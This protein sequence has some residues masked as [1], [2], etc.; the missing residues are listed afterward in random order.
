MDIHLK[1]GQN[2]TQYAWVN[3]PSTTVAE[4]VVSKFRR[5]TFDG[6][7]IQAKIHGQSKLL[8]EFLNCLCLQNNINL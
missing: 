2:E 1:E 7:I 3:C 5:R 4:T 6:R 8:S